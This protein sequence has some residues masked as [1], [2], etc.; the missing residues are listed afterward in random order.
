M[1]LCSRERDGKTVLVSTVT[2]SCIWCS[3]IRKTNWERIAFL[4][5]DMKGNMEILGIIGLVILEKLPASNFDE[6]Q[7]ICFLDACAFGVTLEIHC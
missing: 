2:I 3:V 4:Q 7:F 1:N 6:V 5:T